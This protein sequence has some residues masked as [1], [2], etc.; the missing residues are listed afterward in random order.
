M[1]FKELMLKRE[2]CRKYDGRPVPHDVLLE[3]METAC[4]SPSACNSQPW[5]LIAAEGEVAKQISQDIQKSGR[6]QFCENVGSFIV[7]CE[8][9]ATLRAFV[10]KESQYY[11]QMDLG[12]IT[13]ALTLAAAD[14]GLSTCILG[15]FDE[16]S[17]RKTLSIPDEIP[18]RLIISVGYAAE[19]GVRDKVR[20]DESETISFDRF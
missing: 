17:V 7:L 12:M 8:T 19:D 5:K 6:N 11:A 9:P 2:S 14:K 13:M 20:K 3:L 10:N 1:T 15:L 18:I 16:P 4:L